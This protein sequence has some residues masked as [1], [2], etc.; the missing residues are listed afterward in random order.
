MPPVK[1]IKK[2]QSV[3]DAATGLHVKSAQLPKISRGALEQS[4]QMSADLIEILFDAKQ[5][6]VV[7]GEVGQGQYIV[8]ACRRGPPGRP[9]A[10][11][12]GR[13][14]YGSKSFNQP[15]VEDLVEAARPRRHHRASHQRH[16]RSPDEVLGVSSDQAQSS[17]K[18]AKKGPA[19]LSAEPAL[20]DFQT[21]YAGRRPQL[22][23]RRVVDD[24]E[25]PVSAYLKIAR[26][27][28]FAFLFESVEGGAWRGRYS[29]IAMRPELIWRCYG[30]RAEMARGDDVAAGRFTAEPW[31]G[32]WR[33]SARPGRQLTVRPPAA[34]PCR[35][36]VG[37][38]VR[39]DRL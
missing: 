22:V 13:A 25:T 36:H 8:G 16:R 3:N 15:L 21:A 6:D 32:R 19:L 28:P 30:D 33:K 20:D 31:A 11:G 12:A 24:L 39:G 17:A 27:E 1:A 2:G 10:G 38:R 5:G 18:K 35:P 29:V 26:A 4:R 23:W 37:G 7:D 14:A 9:D 34:G